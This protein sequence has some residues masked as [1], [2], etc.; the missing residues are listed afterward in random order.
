MTERKYKF[1]I[2]IDVS[3]H[4]LDVAMSHRKGGIEIAYDEPG[5]NQLVS[6]LPCKVDTLIVLEAS[7]GYERGVVNALRGKGYRVAVVNAKRVRDFAKAG[8]HLA[9]TD[10]IDAQVILDYGKTFNPKA[11]KLVLEE[12]RQHLNYLSRRTQLVRMIA[13]EKR[14]LEHSCS[15]F[16]EAIQNHIV[17]LKKA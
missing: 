15:E 7:G 10:R 1:Y 6:K 11:Q 4:K 13:T 9:K 14:H 8:G 5:L 17:Y 2:G 12:E 3:K 16:R